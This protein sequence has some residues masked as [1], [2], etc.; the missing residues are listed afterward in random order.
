VARGR[1]R[2]RRDA[3]AARGVTNLVDRANRGRDSTGAFHRRLIMKPGWSRITAIGAAL[4]ALLGAAGGAAA[5]D[6]L[7]FAVGPFQPTATDTQKIYAP[8]F[9][10]IGKALGVEYD[11][12]ATT[13]WAGLAT[14]MANDQADVAW[15]GP[16]GYVLANNEGGAQAVAMVKYDGKP[17]YYAIIVAKPGLGIKNWPADAKGKSISFADAGSTSGWLIPTF[18]FKSHG[19]DPKTFFNYRD[20]ASHPANELAVVNGQVDLATDYDRNRNN[21]IET[22]RIPADATEIVWTSDPLPNDALAVRKGLDPALVAKLQ[23][24][25]L[26][27]DETQAKAIMP[28]HY[29]GWIAATHKDYR[30]IE[31]AGQA[32]GKLKVSAN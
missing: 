32:V 11:L 23:Q 13:D 27:I 31:Q 18:W 14:A 28:A 3:L 7:H 9:A 15:M 4:T 10:Y 16:W 24:A 12:Q 20:G 5:A 21:M 8:F 25:V 22:G 30:M 6:K 1:R 17:V 26:A 2:R 29:T 19:I